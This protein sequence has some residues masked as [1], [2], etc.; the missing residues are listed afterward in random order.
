VIFVLPMS[1][2]S[3]LQKYF[4]PQIVSERASEGERSLSLCRELD[5]GGPR[6]LRR[7][8]RRGTVD[9]ATDK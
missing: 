9:S 2:E 6:Q 5:A 7:G 4:K 3:S 8:L 1:F